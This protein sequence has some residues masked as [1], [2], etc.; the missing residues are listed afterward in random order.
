MNDVG[1]G[2]PAIGY[3]A[4][5]NLV[6]GVKASNDVCVVCGQPPTHMTPLLL[7]GELVGDDVA[8]DAAGAGGEPAPAR[9]YTV[10]CPHCDGDVRLAVSASSVA[11]VG[12]DAPGSGP[13]PDDTGEPVPAGAPSGGGPDEPELPA[14]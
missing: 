9:E 5:D 10:T 4:T 7:G 3:C 2:Y 13:S 14:S 8:G 6:F 11:V 1:E 12:D